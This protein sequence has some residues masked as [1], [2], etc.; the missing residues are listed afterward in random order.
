M[1]MMHRS[2]DPAH[3]RVRAAAT[4]VVAAGRARAGRASVTLSPL[5]VADALTWIGRPFAGFFFLDNRIVVSIGRSAGANPAIRRIEWSLVTAVERQDR[6]G[7]ARDPR[8]RARG[9]AG[10]S[11]RTP[12]AAEPRS[13]A[14]RCRSA[15]SPPRLRD[16]LRAD[17]GGRSWTIAVGPALVVARPG[18]AT[19]RAA[20]AGLSHARSLVPHRPRPIW[21]VSIRLGLLLR[22]RR[23]AGLRLPPERRH[24]FGGPASGRAG[25]VAAV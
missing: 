25:V 14:S 8:C 13:F 16:H 19:L 2:A 4:A 23:H 1:P 15:A 9:P 18:V 24:F 20:F 3:Q 11:P 22:A 21:P 6:G 5:H 17:A 10:S 7:R 12:C